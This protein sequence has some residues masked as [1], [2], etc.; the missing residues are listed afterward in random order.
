MRSFH[1]FHLI[2]IILKQTSRSLTCRYGINIFVSNEQTPSLSYNTYFSYIH[3]F[4]SI[5]SS[6]YHKKLPGSLKLPSSF[7]DGTNNVMAFLAIIEN[8]SA[9]RAGLVSASIALH[10]YAIFV[11]WLG[12][13]N[14]SHHGRGFI[15]SVMFISR[16]ARYI[17]AQAFWFYFVWYGRL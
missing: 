5:W 8:E 16:D 1:C 15:G 2:L 17:A 7:K 11:C 9:S 6:K 4:V 14:T 3:F 13:T 12:P 10:T